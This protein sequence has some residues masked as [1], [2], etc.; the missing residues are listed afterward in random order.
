LFLTNAGGAAATLA[1]I[2]AT[3]TPIAMV[4]KISLILFVVG[5][6][7]A[8]VSRARYFHW[9]SALFWNW[10]NLIRQLESGAKTWDVVVSS[11]TEKSRP[12]FVDYAIPY[13]S[14]ACFVA[15]AVVGAIALLWRGVS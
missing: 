10:K 9:V 7:L 15:G 8:G 2:G 1:F 14:F 12:K 11:D 5:V 6:V 13:L 3:K 4:A